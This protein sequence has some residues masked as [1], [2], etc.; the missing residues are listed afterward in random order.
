M[1]VRVVWLYYMEGRTQAE[2]ADAFS[3]NRLRVNKIIAEARRSGLVSITVNSR[4]TTCVEIEQQL[5]AEFGLSRA[6]IVPTPEDGNLIPV[7]LGQ[8]TA[9]LMTQLL[10]SNAPMGV[11]VGWGATLREMIRHMPY[12]RRPDIRVNSIMGGLTNGIEINTFDIVSDLARHLNAQ[13]SYL[14]APIYAGSPQSR[15]AILAQD[16]FRD[17][18][19]QIAANDIIVLSIGDMT[20]RSLLMRYGLPKDVTIDELVGKG[21]CGDVLAQFVDRDGT[22][23]DHPI[24]RRAIA[25]PLDALRRAANVIFAAGGINKAQA[26]AAV[27]LSGLGNVLVCDEDT[28]RAA[29]AFAGK[30]RQGA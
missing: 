29:I 13:C 25:P 8:A 16:V 28:A 17:A 3:T 2:I 1:Q 23:I 20:E 30:R 6:V 26:I 4:L 5:V 10:A 18:F 11:G 27:L 14:A 19:E 9:D 7:L 12:L 24:N 15:D 21:A 22:P